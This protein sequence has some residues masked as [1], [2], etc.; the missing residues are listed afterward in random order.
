MAKVK[1]EDKL[2]AFCTKLTKSNKKGLRQYAANKDMRLYE[3]V[4][5]VIK[6]GLQS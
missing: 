5:E 2:E 6:K 1:T 3:A 4:N